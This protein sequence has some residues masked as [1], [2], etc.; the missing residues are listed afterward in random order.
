[1]LYEQRK[2]RGLLFH[3]LITGLA[4]L[5][6][7][8]Y[9][10]IWKEFLQRSVAL[11]F[12]PYLTVHRHGEWHAIGQEQREKAVESEVSCGDYLPMID[13]CQKRPDNQCHL[14]RK[15]ECRSF[16][17]IG[18]EVACTASVTELPV[19]FVPLDGDLITTFMFCA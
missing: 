5:C 16:K 18:D 9:P 12:A 14:E 6:R 11:P 15:Q 3:S 17:A 7:T 8:F 10:N 13:H 19:T 4:S 2:R 1:M